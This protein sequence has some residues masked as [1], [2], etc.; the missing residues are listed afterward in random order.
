MTAK[1]GR[2]TQWKNTFKTFLA[3]VDLLKKILL[4]DLEPP[5]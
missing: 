5:F 4:W 3:K 1:S 2:G